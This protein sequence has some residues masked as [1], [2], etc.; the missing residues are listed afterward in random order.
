MIPFYKKTG[1]KVKIFLV[2]VKGVGPVTLRGRNDIQQ[3][4]CLWS[5]CQS[6]GQVLKGAPRR[7]V[8][9][10]LVSMIFFFFLMFKWLPSPPFGVVL[11]FGS[12][13]LY[14]LLNSWWVRGEIA[15][16]F[17]CFSVFGQCLSVRL[18]YSLLNFV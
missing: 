17:L 18:G 6:I 3:I 15:R 13:F 10:S 4:V 1:L 11:G 8:K 9:V 7:F 12:C 5:V 16:R 14:P 2:L